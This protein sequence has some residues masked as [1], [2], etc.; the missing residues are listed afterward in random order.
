M[1]N[2]ANITNAQDVAAIWFLIVFGACMLFPLF[3][4]IW[5]LGT[6]TGDRPAREISCGACTVAVG[7][8]SYDERCAATRKGA[9]S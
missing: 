6:R 5:N 3:G 9:R 1:E 4:A 7:A 8:H 2:L